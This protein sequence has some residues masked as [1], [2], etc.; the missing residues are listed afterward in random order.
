MS[1]CLVS[2]M[3]E[4][5]T[6]G[7]RNKMTAEDTGNVIGR[8]R[9]GQPTDDEVKF[10]YQFKE[11]HRR[12]PERRAEIFAC[13]QEFDFLAVLGVAIINSVVKRRGEV[14]RNGRRRLATDAREQTKIRFD[15]SDGFQ[16]GVLG[17]P[18]DSSADTRDEARTIRS[19]KN[20]EVNFA[21][22]V[23]ELRDDEFAT[24]SVPVLDARL[25]LFTE[26]RRVN[27]VWLKAFVPCAHTSIGADAAH[28]GVF[29]CCELVRMS[30][31]AGIVG[32]VKEIF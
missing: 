24:V 6:V 17:F 8:M 18:G 12:A 19:A 22:G 31:D 32:T 15:C 21:V 29:D 1:E 10:L 28:D 3:F 4:S 11:I 14:V 13:G 16:D 27:D 23:V 7:N 26:E 9:L 5:E 25:N 20:C 30:G 2:R